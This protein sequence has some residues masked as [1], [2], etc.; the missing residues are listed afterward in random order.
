[1]ARGHFISVLDKMIIGDLIKTL[2]AAL[3]TIVIIIVSREFVRVLAKAVKGEVSSET[4]SSIF[5]LKM[6]SAISAFLPAAFFIAVLMVLGRMHRDHEMAALLSTGFGLGRLFRAVFMLSIPLFLVAGGMAFFAAP[7]AEAT[8]EQMI[9][10]DSQSVELRG[11]RAGQFSEYQQGDLVFYVE[12]V[13]E[14]KQLRHIFVQDRLHDRLSIVTAKTGAIRDLP[15]GRYLVLEDGERYQGEPGQLEFVIEKFSQYALRL[16][17]VT[18]KLN[19]NLESVPTLRLLDSWN[20]PDIAELQQRLAI[21]LG[22]LVLGML[23][24]PLSHVSPRTGI[25]SNLFTAFL[26]YFCY[27]NLRRLC[28]SWVIN[29]VLP[30]WSGFLA[31]Y[32]LM[33]MAIALIMIRLY[34]WQWVKLSLTRKVAV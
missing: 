8:V 17:A 25:Y 5:A 24:V 9:H 7:W 33:L 34:G 11:L 20:L 23:A 10:R 28:N 31:I 29:G 14:Q 21:P 4:I 22:V 6:V 12:D 1:M 18:R 16:E 3:S 27:A 30:P 2:T 15:G 26:I 19:L 13:T 32:L